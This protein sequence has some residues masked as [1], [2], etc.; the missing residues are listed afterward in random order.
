MSLK[1]SVVPK[2]S[3]T[4]THVFLSPLKLNPIETS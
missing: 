1:E 4:Q 2:A 3:V